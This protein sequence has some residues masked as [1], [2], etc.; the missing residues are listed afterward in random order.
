M[1][2][3]KL[4]QNFYYTHTKVLYIHYV[5]IN[6]IYFDI[7]SI[8]LDPCLTVIDF[9]LNIIFYCSQEM[10]WIGIMMHSAIIVG[11]LLPNPSIHNSA[12]KMIM[13]R[14]WLLPILKDILKN[15]TSINAYKYRHQCFDIMFFQFQFDI[16]EYIFHQTWFQFCVSCL[17]RLRT[18][19]LLV[20]SS[21]IPK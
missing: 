2:N 5:Q 6:I 3:T 14:L 7:D 8:L 15:I 10:D 16:I 13:C 12:I 4:I 1:P 21:V 20:E 11:V 9:P 19:W 17:I 18:L